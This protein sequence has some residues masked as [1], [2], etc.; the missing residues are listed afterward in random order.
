M[1]L[2]ELRLEPDGLAEVVDGFLQSG[3]VLRGDA[4]R[5][6]GRG[7]LGV[8]V[9]RLASNKRSPRPGLDRGTGSRGFTP[10]G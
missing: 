5:V 2:G 6:P 8:T 7:P 1:G 9:V 3:L 10:S 4:E